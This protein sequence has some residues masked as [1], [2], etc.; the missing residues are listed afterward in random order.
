[1]KRDMSSCQRMPRESSRQAMR[2]M[3]QVSCTRFHSS[4]I[5]TAYFTT[6][7]FIDIRQAATSVV[8]TSTEKIIN[9][10]NAAIVRPQAVRKPSHWTRTEVKPPAH[11][12]MQLSSIDATLIHH[13]RG[14]GTVTP[15]YSYFG[16]VHL[17]N[18]DKFQVSYLPC[19]RRL[20]SYH[21]PSSSSHL[22]WA[23]LFES[24]IMGPPL[25]VTYHGPSSSSHLSWALLFHVF[26]LIEWPAALGM[27]HHDTIH[28]AP[29]SVACVRACASVSAY[30][31]ENMSVC[32]S[33]CIRT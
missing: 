26:Q 32:L 31:N 23:L 8:T 14:I 12:C 25:R 27:D 3:L 22:S 1:M 5:N 10:S 28:R 6:T 16:H 11:R 21:G 7:T 13:S 17:H 18:Q 4:R 33:V 9:V 20:L 30:V 24:P 19:F 2:H 15:R 29:V